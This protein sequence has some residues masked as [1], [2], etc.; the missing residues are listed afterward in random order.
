MSNPGEQT[1]K[2]QGEGAES[3]A[4]PGFPRAGEGAISEGVLTCH[5]P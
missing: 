5:L 1:V 2:G 3:V 4:D